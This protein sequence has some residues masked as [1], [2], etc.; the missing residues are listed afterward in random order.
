MSNLKYDVNDYLKHLFDYSTD[1]Y[2]Q[3]MNIGNDK[4]ININNVSDKSIENVVNKVLARNNKDAYISINTTYIPWREV[5]NIRQFR[6]LYIDLDLKDYP[7]VQAVYDV[8]ILADQGKIPLPT[9][10]IDSGR[11]IHL[12]WRIENAPFQAM[13]TWQ[14]LED[15]LYYNLK[16][17]GADIKATDAVRL[18]RIP[19]SINTKNNSLCKILILDNN[20]EYSMYDLRELYLKKKYKPK[21]KTNKLK[22][23]KS[24]NTES[25][26]IN[27]VFFNSYNLHIQRAQDLLTLVKIRNYDVVGYRNMIIH[28]F[29][30][31]RGIILR[32][33]EILINEV[34]E[35]NNSF[36]EPLKESE[37]KAI[38]KCILK[39]VE[40]FIAYEND[41]RL[42][43]KSKITKNMS[44]N[45]GYWYK[46]STLIERLNISE[47]EQ[48]H[49]KTI[50][51][52]REK[53]DRNN[54]RRKVSRRNEEGLTK[55]EKAK[56][57]LI[58]KIKELKEK[59]L[60][61]TEVAK[62][63]NKSI[64]TIKSYWNL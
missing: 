19:S 60:K 27:N 39:K 3:V 12:Y 63:L 36:L 8:Y 10:V 28:C 51:G 57:D 22:K 11:G 61:Q 26:V 21:I 32:N 33:D 45:G 18:L 16:H 55:R 23:A 53:Y 50:I 48:K 41:L 49:L 46:N 15:Y 13:Y 62:E 17:L 59:G 29:A 4:S 38:C 52:T 9:M 34:K 30:Y 7:K 58:N 54:I 5:K 25:K 14:E 31:W 56:Q 24:V 44:E 47:E 20:I 42:G 37:I 43:I 35:L 1:G 6:A 40:Q 64:R 2:L